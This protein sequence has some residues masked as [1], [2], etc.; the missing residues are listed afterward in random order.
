MKNTE[1]DGGEFMSAVFVEGVC[2]CY[3]QIK[4]CEC[5]CMYGVEKLNNTSGKP[6][7]HCQNYLL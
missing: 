5:T 6:S 2:I 1:L 4:H 7:S 3:E